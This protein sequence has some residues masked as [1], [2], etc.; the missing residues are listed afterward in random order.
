MN[1]TFK[2]RNWL[3]CSML[4]A[5]C[6]SAAFAGGFGG[7]FGHGSG[8]PVFHAPAVH[9]VQTMQM[10]KVQMF[11]ANPIYPQNSSPNPKILTTKFPPLTGV[12][13]NLTPTNGGLKFPGKVITLPT[14]G[15]PPVLI[16][17]P[18]GGGKFPG[19]G[20]KL[21]P[22]GLPPVVVN[23][24]TGGGGTTNPPSGGMGNGHHFP[25]WLLPALYGNWGYGYGGGYPVYTGGVATTPV[26]INEA[27]VVTA[28]PMNPA[29]GKLTLK[30]GETY[31]I[32]NES[33]GENAGGLALMVN[34][35]TLPVQINKWDAGQIS[36]TLPMAGL[37]QATD[38][39]FHIVKA[40]HAPA[41]A[42]AVTLIAAN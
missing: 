18:A 5:A 42:V 38:G 35:L 28:T 10:Q 40:D 2:I 32:V 20:I 17:P 6:H 12:G 23:P 8:G 16:N 9:N 30:M 7:N 14:N 39:M 41:K 13:G 1:A 15:L 34:G 24:P 22:G 3:G 11:K 26:V 21:P 27:P 19:G 36:F 25:Y 4:L 33:F 29:A 31:T 37:T